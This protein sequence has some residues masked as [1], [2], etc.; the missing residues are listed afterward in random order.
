MNS[1]QIGTGYL[2]NGFMVL[3]TGFNNI[4]NSF[5]FISAS[6]NINIDVYTRHARLGHIGQDRMRRL[7][8]EGLLGSLTKIKMSICENCL[9]GKTTR[10][11]FGKGTRA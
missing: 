5:S 3:D 7:A 4:N 6:N 8:K 1:L 9:A 2:L 11:P 10:K